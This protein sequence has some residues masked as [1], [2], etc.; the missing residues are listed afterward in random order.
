MKDDSTWSAL[1]II[2]LVISALPLYF[3]IYCI[4]LTASGEGATGDG[5]GISIMLAI[6]SVA[7]IICILSSKSIEKKS[8]ELR[9][10]EQKIQEQKKIIANKK[11]RKLKDIHSLTPIQYEK[12][13]KALF[14]KM[15]YVASETKRT[16]DE[17]ID[18]FL[19]KDDKTEVVQCKN[20]KNSVSVPTVREFYGSM[21]DKGVTKGYIVTPSVFTMP[22]IKFASDKGIHLIDGDELVEWVNQFEILVPESGSN[23]SVGTNP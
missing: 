15:G 19:K 22:A 20:W 9:Q 6:F 1:R 21:L 5:W 2:A 3:L 10:E 11:I 14:E 7:V 18:L 16:G 13:I 23:P 4:Y 17:G 8:E 12:V